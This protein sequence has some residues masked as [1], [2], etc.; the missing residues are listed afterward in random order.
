[1]LSQKSPGIY[2]LDGVLRY[3]G[4][5]TRG[6]PRHLENQATGAPYDS[7]ACMIVASSK[8]IYNVAGIA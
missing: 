3:C 5:K 1:M 6:N 4:H 8:T 7:F 2:L